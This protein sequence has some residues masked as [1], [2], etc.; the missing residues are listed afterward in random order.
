MQSQRRINGHGQR[1]GAKAK[2]GHYVNKGRKCSRCCQVHAKEYRCAARNGEGRN[3]WKLGCFAV[4]WRPCVVN[5][6][7]ASYD[8]RQVQVLY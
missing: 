5:E 7:T 4:A 8:R 3:C 1:K 2:Q 6:V